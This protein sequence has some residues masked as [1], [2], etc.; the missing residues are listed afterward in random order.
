MIILFCSFSALQFILNMNPYPSM[1]MAVDS[2][3]LLW[4]WD[5][6]GAVYIRSDLHLA[7]KS[8]AVE[9]EFNNWV[10]HVL[11]DEQVRHMFEN[12]NLFCA[13]IHADVTSRL[14]RALDLLALRCVNKDSKENCKKLLKAKKVRLHEL[15]CASRE[16]RIPHIIFAN[17]RNVLS[18]VRRREVRELLVVVSQREEEEQRDRIRRLRL[19]ETLLEKWICM[20][21]A[22]SLEGIYYKPTIVSFDVENAES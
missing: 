6:L 10:F 14:Q 20:T 19:L 2:V 13:Q 16:V 12:M 17:V 21:L 11:T 15:V 3:V 1:M 8:N 22:V 5:F 18:D 7:L 4:V 9:R